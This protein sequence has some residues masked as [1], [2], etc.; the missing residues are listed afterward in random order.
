MGPEAIRRI[1]RDQST[2]TKEIR[3]N[4]GSRFVVLGA[5]HWMV[6]P[7]YLH[8]MLRNGVVHHLSYR[9]IASVGPK[10]QRAK[11]RRA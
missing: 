6:G 3:M 11:R 10:E 1:L 9:N 5:E 4:D 2:R 8:V 7:D